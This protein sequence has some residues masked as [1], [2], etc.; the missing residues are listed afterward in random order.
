[1]RM[2]HILK[3]PKCSQYTMRD[4]CPSCNEKTI[5]PK[6]ARY[7]PEDRYAKY[8]RQAKMEGLIK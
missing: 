2:K 1:M 4:K 6:P 3:C 5:S 7:S 8:R